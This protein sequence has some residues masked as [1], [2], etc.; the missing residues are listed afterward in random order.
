M[1]AAA[2][3]AATWQRYQELGAG[4]ASQAADAIRSAVGQIWPGIVKVAN[5]AGQAL[6][7]IYRAAAPPNWVT[8]ESAPL[9]HYA[10]AVKLALEEGIPL[11]WVPDPETVRLLMAVPGAAPGRSAVL[12]KILE[13]R[14]EIILDYCQARLDQ[15]TQ[16]PGTPDRRKRMIDVACQS[17][18]ALRADLPAPAQSAAANLT[19]QLLRELFTPIDGR[20]VY[21]TTCRRVE[22]LSSQVVV[23]SLSFLAILREMATLMPVPRALTEWWPNQDMELPETFSRHATAHAIAESGQ[24]NSVNAL[25][26]IM[27]SVSLLCQEA[28]S[29]WAALHTFTWNS[30]TDSS[31]TVD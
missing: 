29:G 3:A 22:S 30:P 11:A 28:A 5:A 17:I 9:L 14:S 23:M 15:I 6:G 24:V 2:E 26:G 4:T 18:Q 21:G 20:Y 8:G 31:D 19:D 16:N 7:Q 1:R 13:E 25:I 10:D 27:L 12:R